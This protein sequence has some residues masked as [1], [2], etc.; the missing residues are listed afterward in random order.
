MTAKEKNDEI[1]NIL[2]EYIS[3]K[4]KYNPTYVFQSVV[5]NK[6]PLI[7]FEKRSNPTDSISQDIYKLDKVINMNFEISVFAVNQE[8]INA[9]TICEDLSQ[10]VSELFEDYYGMQ[11]GLDAHLKNINT[12]NASK[13]VLHYSCKYNPRRNILY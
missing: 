8:N 9:N 12:S 4:S 3:K 13:C 7:V 1:F 11:G 5:E 2:K 10:L 6:Y